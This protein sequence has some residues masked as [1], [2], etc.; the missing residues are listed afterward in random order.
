M[1]QRD[2]TPNSD[3]PPYSTPSS[4]SKSAKGG[5]DD[6]PTKFTHPPPIG[7]VS[8]PASRPANNHHLGEARA[9]AFN[10][11]MDGS[12][13]KTQTEHDEPGYQSATSKITSSVSGIKDAVPTSTEE[14]KARLA[15][16]Q[17][18]IASLTGRLTGGGG[19]S[20]DDG[21]NNSGELRKRTVADKAHEVKESVMNTAVQSKQ[22][23]QQR[24]PDNAA[25]AAGIAVPVVAALCL[26]SFL[27]GYIFF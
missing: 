4:T 26:V 22:Q 5:D 27:L 8:V 11:A 9:S 20:N 15:E 12:D 6:T 2:T 16:A 19:E 21:S 17:A 14:L 13:N 24:M 7:P 1:T 3:P 23:L 18:Q 25:A 10:P